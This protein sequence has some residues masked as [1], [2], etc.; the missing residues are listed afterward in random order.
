MSER[1][2]KFEANVFWKKPVFEGQQEFHVFLSKTMEE[3]GYTFVQTVELELP[4]P[5]GFDPRATQLHSLRQQEKKVRAEF[6]AR[7]TDLQRQIG[8][9]LAI[10]NTVEA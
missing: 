9:L 5:E 10:E 3:Y 8:Q 7:I 1:T 2:I 4:E 6:Q